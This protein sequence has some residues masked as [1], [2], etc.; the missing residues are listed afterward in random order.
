MPQSP[1]L[2]GE[3][4]VLA[5]G[6]GDWR[7]GQGGQRAKK[8]TPKH[9]DFLFPIVTFQTVPE[10]SHRHLILIS[11]RLRLTEQNRKVQ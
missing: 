6:R 7:S 5:A 10:A 4:G 9:V 2:F 11:W 1:D 8:A 3:A